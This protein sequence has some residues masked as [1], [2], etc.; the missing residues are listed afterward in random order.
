MKTYILIHGAWLNGGIWDRVKPLLLKAGHEALAPELPGNGRDITP[1]NEV[2]LQSYIDAIATLVRDREQV[3]LV[4]H[5]MAG[6]IISSVAE[7]MPTRVAHLVYLA[8]Y[9][10]PNGASVFSFEQAQQA[11]GSS[12]EKSPQGGSGSLRF[13]PDFSYSMI[14]AELVPSEFCNTCTADDARLLAQHLA[15][16]PSGPQRD[17]VHISK[18]A[19]GCVPRTYIKTLQDKAL[20]TRLQEV[21]LA[22]APGTSVV[23]MNTDH[24]PF[25]CAPQELANA[26]VS[27]AV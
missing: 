23:E 25:Y 9:M 10:L 21:M 27:L 24:S 8:A 12:Q 4:G 18:S 3:V 1:L 14:D 7:L 13:A 11:L 6:I 5:S 19:W 20:E 22:M 16:Q 15:A 17:P 26:L 2:N